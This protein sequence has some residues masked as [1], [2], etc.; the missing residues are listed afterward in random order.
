MFT[1]CPVGDPIVLY[2][3]LHALTPYAF[4]LAPC[5]PFHV[6]NDNDY[7]LQTI[8]NHFDSVVATSL[9]PLWHLNVHTHIAGQ[10]WF[11]IDDR[12]PVK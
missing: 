10:A 8:I 1:L 12:C 11:D 2:G 9:H 5:A 6:M 3:A 4:S 7:V